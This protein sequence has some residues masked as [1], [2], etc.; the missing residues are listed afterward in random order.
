M[1]LAIALIV[2]S[3]TLIGILVI[4]LVVCAAEIDHIYQEME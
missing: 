1:T 2:G 4:A 3:L